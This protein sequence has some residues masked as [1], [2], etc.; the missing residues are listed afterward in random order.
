[1]KNI[2]YSLC[3]GVVLMFIIFVVNAGMFAILLSLKLL[4]PT[5]MYWGLTKY[6]FTQYHWKWLL[7]NMGKIKVKYEG[8]SDTLPKGEPAL[9]FSNHQD[10]LDFGIFLITYMEN[11]IRS[12]ETKWV[13]KTAVSYIPFFGWVHWLVG[14]LF[15]KR[16]WEKDA[17]HIRDWLSKFKERQFKR[18]VIFPEGT[19]SR[20]KKK[21]IE[22]QQFAKDHGLPVLDH[23]LYPRTKGFSFIAKYFRDHPGSVDYVYDYT[24]GYNPSGVGIGQ[25]AQGP[26]PVDIHI[27]VSRHKISEIGK[28]ESDFA[29][30]CVKRF[31]VKDQLLKYFEQH[32]CFPSV[33][34]VAQIEK[35]LFSQ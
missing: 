34:E 2:L 4:L 6:F 30:W 25:F 18:I 12:T 29:S 27:Y 26:I 3:F 19:R 32:L 9:M 22:S 8:E 13:A 7:F 35:K 10:D 31:Q 14:D 17:A 20:N 33:K 16:S 15:L 28:E 5:K 24:F 23:V 1:M 11:G 21:L